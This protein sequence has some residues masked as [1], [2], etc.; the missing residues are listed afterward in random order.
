MRPMRLL[1]VVAALILSGWGEVGAEGRPAAIG[2]RFTPVGEAFEVAIAFTKVPRYSIFTLVGPDRVVIDLD[3]VAF[4]FPEE[5]R[6][7]PVQAVRA[8]LFQPGT[9]R[10]VLDLV[11]PYGVGSLSEVVESGELVLQLV[12]Q[13]RGDAIERSGKVIA[14]TRLPG[15]TAA[16]PAP[17][18]APPV[19]IAIDPGH[20]GVDPGAIGTRGTFEKTVTL[21]FARALKARIEQ[22]GRFKAMLTRQGDQFLKLRD[23]IA[24]ARK[25]GAR[26]FISLH[27]DSHRDRGFRGASVYTLSE[28]ASDAEGA[29]LA[30]RENKSDLIGGVDL[31]HENEVVASILIDLAQRETKNFSVQFASMALAQL[32][33][34]T[35][36]IRNTQRFA[37][38]A[39]LKS[40]D[41]PSV[42]V[43]LGYL[44]NP[45]D[46]KQLLSPKFQARLAEAIARAVQDYFDW[47]NKLQQG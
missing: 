14:S 35:K 28:D 22:S 31:T 10:M 24:V 23:R 37:G 4:R 17:K 36:L 38:F 20:G 43:E 39:V 2:V 26:L 3:Q 13:S 7:G 19:V 18:P 40:P 47:Q 42:L 8:G 15:E 9:S 46:E 27:A 32:G 1:V 6:G 25:A 33:Q 30:A 34:E 5:S 21:A 11:S 12:P 44:S 41:I 45:N 29:A 16:S